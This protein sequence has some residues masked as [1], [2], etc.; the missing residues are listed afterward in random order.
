MTNEE[1]LAE[2][3]RALRRDEKQA[4]DD[5]KALLLLLLWRFRQALLS[6][7]PE[8]GPSR[9]LIANE[10]L[11][12]FVPDLRDYNRQFLNIL[13]PVLERVDRDHSKRAAAFAGYAIDGRDY[14]PR[15]GDDLL[16]GTRSGGQSLLTLFTPAPT[17]ESPYMRAHLRAVK[18]KIDAGIMRGDSTREIAKGIVAERTR[19]GFIQ[20]R[21]SR[22]TLY[23]QLRNRDTA[24]IANSIWDVSAYAEKALLPKLITPATPEASLRWRWYAT[25]DPAT[26]PICRPLHLTTS[27]K[28]NGF[29]YIPP[30]HPRCRCR[31]LPVV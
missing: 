20:P 10:L 29:P 26:C 18:A 4:E 5:T 3:V 28:Y 22:G 21:N 25:L 17:G 16:S 7:L 2:T 30:V 1:Y 24:L 8:T 27:D 19:Q 11:R 6:S 15:T 14:K 31:I 12:S 9:A 23:S 13:L